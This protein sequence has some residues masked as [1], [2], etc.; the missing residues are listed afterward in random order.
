M[1]TVVMDSLINNNENIVKPIINLKSTV[2]AIRV[3]LIQSTIRRY[4]MFQGLSN[5]K[6]T[7]SA[8]SFYAIDN[9]LKA[10]S[11]KPKGP[12]GFREKKLQKTDPV[13]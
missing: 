1:S 4:K 6:L 9:I 5:E 13:N 8:H 11:I 7:T 10:A 2:V 12:R 3:F